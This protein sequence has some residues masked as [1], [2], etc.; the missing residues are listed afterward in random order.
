M[1]MNGMWSLCEYAGQD[2]SGILARIRGAQD[3]PCVYVASPSA[4]G[5]ERGLFDH[6]GG[7]CRSANDFLTDGAEEE[8]PER[9]TPVGTDDSK[10]GG[11][12]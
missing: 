7:R 6:H 10:P 4:T 12:C 2:E 11:G 3:D 8:T 5:D 1:L 9:P